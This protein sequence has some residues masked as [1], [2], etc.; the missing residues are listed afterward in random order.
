MQHWLCMLLAC[1]DAH[2]STCIRSASCAAP[3]SGSSMR[4]LGVHSSDSACMRVAS[5]LAKMPQL[6]LPTSL[7]LA[8]SSRYCRP[9]CRKEMR[10]PGGTSLPLMLLLCTKLS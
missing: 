5:L 3:D 8:S 1:A 6:Q 9:F 2:A 7:R 10:A 4:A